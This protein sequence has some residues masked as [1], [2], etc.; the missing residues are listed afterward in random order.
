MSRARNPFEANARAAKC[1]ALTATLDAAFREQG[2]DPA[3]ADALA[4]VE[5]LSEAGWTA[6]ASVAR[7]RQPSPTSIAWVVESYRIRVAALRGATNDNA[8]SEV[9]F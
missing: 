3:G 8:E 2:I 7:V 5:G 4:A 9:P 6:C 1:A